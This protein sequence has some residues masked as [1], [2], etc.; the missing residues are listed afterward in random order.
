MTT[1]KRLAILS[2]NLVA[3]CVLF[4]ISPSFRATIR[5]KMRGGNDPV[6]TGEQVVAVLSNDN[7]KE[8]VGG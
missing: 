7:G 3:G 1:V 2:I 4:L 8:Y 5:A 6:S